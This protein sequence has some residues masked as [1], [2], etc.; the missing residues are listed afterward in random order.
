MVVW[1]GMKILIS[2][3]SAWNIYN[4]RAGLIRFLLEQGHEVV[5]VAPDDGYVREVESLGCRF[6][7]IHMNTHGVH[8][9]NEFMLF[10]RYLRLLWSERP[11]VYLGYT[12]KPN[13]YGS[14][15]AMLLRI[16]V[17]NNI[18][19]L[20]AVYIG[21]GAMSRVVS[22]L[23]RLSLSQSSRVFFQNSDDLGMFVSRGLVKARIADILPGSGV[24]LNR[25]SYTPLPE[26]AS[27]GGTAPFRFLLVGRVLWDKGVGEYVEA[28][29]RLKSIYPFVDFCILGSLDS[30]NPSAIERSQ[31]QAWTD[32]G[33]VRYLGVTDDVPAQLNAA[34][35]VVLA[36]YREGAPRTLLEAS[37]MGRPI[38]TT[39]VPGCRRVVEDGITG[40]L[41]Q[42]RDAE[43]LAQCLETVLNM[44]PKALEAMGRRGREKME[45]EFDERLVFHQYNL[46]IDDCKIPRQSV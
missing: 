4:F 33:V 46:A 39:D 30:A 31:M 11:D 34:H 5:A 12:V 24:D 13:V 29:R 38:I 16:H 6:V 36:S 7:A 42:P 45:F 41:C 1:F 15:A 20:G 9:V 8:P 17:I 14:L 25:F 21:G 2:L 27:R 22:A 3:N 23:Y 18:A 26:M 19:G 35:C 32:E 28:A 37:A 43:S 44:T 40:L 10:C